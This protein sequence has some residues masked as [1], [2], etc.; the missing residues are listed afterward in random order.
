VLPGEADCF[1]GGVA[2]IGIQFDGEC[3]HA[4]EIW[5][6]KHEGITFVATRLLEEGTREGGGHARGGGEGLRG[7][8]N[9]KRVEC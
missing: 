7:D 3:E 8:I 1:V 4:W 9:V 2:G 5:F 6:L